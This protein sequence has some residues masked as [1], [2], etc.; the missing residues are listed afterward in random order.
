MSNAAETS[1]PPAA[2]GQGFCVAVD[3]GT[4]SFRAWLLSRDGDV[5]AE[6]RGPEGM[7]HCATAGFEPVLRA[8]VERLG[9]AKDLPVLICGM[10]GARQGWIEA[11]Y[12]DTP[13]Q[14]AE[15][16]VRAVR[17][18]ADFADIRILPGL[19]QRDPLAPEVMR[20]EETQL[21]G[22]GD[23]APQR[24]VCMPGTHCKWVVLENGWVRRFTT[25]MTGEVFAL[26]RKHSTLAFAVEAG[27]GFDATSPAFLR[28]LEIGL[29]DP[30]LVLSRLFGVR[31]AQLLEFEGRDEGAAHLSGLLIGAEVVAARLNFPDSA[32]VTL[33]ATG[34]TAGLYGAAFER[35]GLDV[36][37]VD[38]DQAVRQG[39]H[40]AA[41]ILW[42]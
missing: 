34:A 31:A 35:C 42:A 7:T 13:T 14:L 39:L 24:L 25:F 21:M 28:A 12:V 8:H 6:S 22:L 36:R 10:A 30:G 27:T 37:C 38:A 17:A 32:E 5:L 18:P 26:L 4:S 40:A 33:V 1:L 29:A 15:L 11:P 16:A 41:R 23:A 3:W 2:Q 19:A 20:G 9:A